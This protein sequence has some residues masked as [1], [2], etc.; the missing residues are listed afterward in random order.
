[1]LARSRFGQYEEC[2]ILLSKLASEG[3]PHIHSFYEW[4]NPITDHPDGSF[5]FR[6]GISAVR[7]AIADII[8]KNQ[9]KVSSSTFSKRVLRKSNLKSGKRS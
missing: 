9:K 3:H 5:P 6:T 8:K 4:I 1:M 2:D 7:L